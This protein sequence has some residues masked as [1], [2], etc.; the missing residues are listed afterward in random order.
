MVQ[1]CIRY[2]SS[3]ICLQCAS[4]YTLNTV[5]GQVLCV[6]SVQ[7]VCPNGFYFTS[8]T[9]R[10]I[11][12]GNCSISDN[13]GQTCYKCMDGYLLRNNICYLIDGCLWPSF[14]SGC[15]SC[16]PGY[17]LNGFLCISLNCLEIFSNNTCKSCQNGFILRN[18]VCIRNIYQC[19]QIDSNGNCARCA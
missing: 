3:Y 9:C 5:N 1:G 14:I 4:G 13:S 12:I 6:L 19:L 17:V 10:V 15:R 7:P 16:L 8:Q 11:P 18:G 2:D